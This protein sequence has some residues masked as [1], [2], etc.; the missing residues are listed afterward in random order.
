MNNNSFSQHDGA[1]RALFENSADALL[2]IEDDQF[3]DCNQSSL[4]LL[5]YDSK[6][7]LYRIHPSKLSPTFQPDGQLSTVKANKMI[8]IAFNRGSNRFE[9]IHTKRNGETFP[10][11]V[12]L[13]LIPFEGKTLLHVVWRDISERKR[14]EHKIQA[15][16]DKLITLNSELESKVASRTEELAK[17]NQALQQVIEDLKL[18]Q[19]QLVESKKLASLGTLVAGVSHE[20]NTPLGICVTASSFLSKELADI[21]SKQQ[22]K[23]LTIHDFNHFQKISLETAQVLENNLKRATHL[24]NSFKQISVD[25][26]A[27]TI[28]E[29]CVHELILNTRLSIK[30]KLRAANAQLEIRSSDTLT[31]HSYPGIL[32]RVLIILIMNSIDHGFRDR[33]ATSPNMIEI[34]ASIDDHTSERLTIKYRDNGRGVDPQIAPKMFDPFFTSNR[35]GGNTGLGMSIAYNLM[36]QKLLGEIE[37][38]KSTNKGAEF[39]L[40]LP[41]CV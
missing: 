5:G 8:E 9:W 39:T 7:Q 16:Q 36:H 37:L 27:D 32:S 40:S 26:S 21:Q 31:L 4:D 17:T 19:S 18:T 41:T 13:T 11:E 25:Q 14:Q 1:Y 33:V 35:G 6:E 28:R 22:N 12:L 10:V 24:I 23:T 15:Y 3:I 29:F 34:E 38:T 2:I 30:P 20:V